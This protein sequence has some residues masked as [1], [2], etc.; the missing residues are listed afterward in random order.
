MAEQ[1]VKQEA[2][3]QKRALLLHNDPS[4]D[5]DEAQTPIKSELVAVLPIAHVK[6]VPVVVE[7]VPIKP[8]NPSCDASDPFVA[9]LGATL[10]SDEGQPI[11][12]SNANLT[13]YEA[14]GIFFSGHWCPPSRKFTPEL[15]K[16]YKMMRANGKSFQIV[17]VSSDESV[18]EF[19]LYHGEMPWLAVPY[20]HRGRMHEL[21]NMFDVEGIPSLV[22]L[23]GKT[24][25]PITT[26][27]REAISEAPEMFPWRNW[28]PDS[29]DAV[30]DVQA[31]DIM[32][33]CVQESKELLLEGEDPAHLAM[34]LIGNGLFPELASQTL[35]LALTIAKSEFHHWA[36]D[37]RQVPWKKQAILKGL[38]IM[39]KNHEERK[40]KSS[41]PA[42]NYYFIAAL[43][44]SLGR[45]TL[46]GCS[47]KDLTDHARMAFCYPLFIT[48]KV[49]FAPPPGIPCIRVCDRFGEEEVLPRVPDIFEEEE[50]E[51][52]A[53]A[54]IN[55]FA[56]LLRLGCMTVGML[57]FGM[58]I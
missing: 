24:A 9:L 32:K 50:V 46:S 58:H 5:E 43:A 13:G 39:K 21:R 3:E 19:K 7:G 22:I 23:D 44:A 31:A 29:A 33:A 30:A 53:Q 47:K 45:T 16:T 51:D 40:K 4:P 15:V 25:V 36:K 8:T 1:R 56:F 11:Q 2:R 38:E 37:I 20:E 41:G 18:E 14:I 10:L 28:E 6:D 12:T 17:F 26:E 27:G 49:N 54:D 34:E 35:G 48:G 57:S 55:C 52:H 42:P